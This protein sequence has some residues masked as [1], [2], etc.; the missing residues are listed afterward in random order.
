MFRETV[1]NYLDLVKPKRLAQYTRQKTAMQVALKTTCIFKMFLKQ[2][3]KN[4]L[5][6]TF[7]ETGQSAISASLFRDCY[8]RVS[9]QRLLFPRLFL[10]TKKQKTKKRLTN[11]DTENYFTND[12]WDIASRTMRGVMPQLTKILHHVL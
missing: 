3:L 9:F 7:L 6:T 2:L 10:E 1:R 12:Q 8:F 11:Q 5:E 4:I